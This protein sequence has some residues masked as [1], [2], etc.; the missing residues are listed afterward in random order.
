MTRRCAEI[1]RGR[2][3]IGRWRGD[4]CCRCCCRRIFPFGLVAVEIGDL[5]IDELF[6]IKLWRTEIPPMKERVRRTQSRRRR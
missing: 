1:G 5:L 6:Q 3:G 4:R 2:R